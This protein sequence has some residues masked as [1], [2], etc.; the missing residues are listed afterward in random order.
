MKKLTQEQLEKKAQKIAEKAE[1]LASKQSRLYLE[2]EALKD[3]ARESGLHTCLGA[4][5]YEL[6][7]GDLMA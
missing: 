3:K 4:P 2:L 7:L 5:I 6:N 1:K